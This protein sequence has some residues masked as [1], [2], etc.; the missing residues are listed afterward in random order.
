MKNTAIIPLLLAFG[1]S[2]APAIV[3]MVTNNNIFPFTDRHISDKRQIQEDSG[4]SHSGPKTGG[5]DLGGIAGIIQGMLGVGVVPKKSYRIV[6]AEPTVPRAGVER[7]QIWYGPYKIRGTGVSLAACGLDE[8]RI[9]TKCD[10]PRR[11]QKP[12]SLWIPLVLAGVWLL[13]TS[14][15]T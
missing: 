10:S 11:R 14:P 2:A 8:S 13:T 4:H 5:S 7:L 1:S 3:G 6:K 12:V 15:R 9:N